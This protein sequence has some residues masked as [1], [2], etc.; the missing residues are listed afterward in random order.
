MNAS[1]PGLAPVTR[2]DRPKGGR[3]G[4]AVLSAGLSDR[5]PAPLPPVRQRA[6]YGGMAVVNTSSRRRAHR[7]APGSPAIARSTQSRRTLATTGKPD[8]DPSSQAGQGSPRQAPSRAPASREESMVTEPG[9]CAAK[10]FQ[11]GCRTFNRL[12]MKAVTAATGWSAAASQARLGFSRPR[13]RMATS[14]SGRR[15]QPCVLR[16]TASTFGTISQI[17]SLHCGCLRS[18]ATFGGGR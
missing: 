16:P 18:A 10:I 12:P 17:R 13:R 4:H 5:P 7:K 9:P 11:D 1:P 6:R 15:V 3:S 8:P 2:T 14:A